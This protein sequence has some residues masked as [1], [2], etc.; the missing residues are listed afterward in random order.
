MSRRLAVRRAAPAGRMNPAGLVLKEI[1][2]GGVV[3]GHARGKGGR[4]RTSQSLVLTE[5][6]TQGETR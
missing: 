3:D 5:I 4:L 2:R 6:L 1:S